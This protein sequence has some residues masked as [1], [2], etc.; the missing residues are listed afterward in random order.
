MRRSARIHKGSHSE[1]DHKT[2]EDRELTMLLEENGIAYVPNLVRIRDL[3]NNYY[4]YYHKLNN[5]HF[6][7]GFIL[8]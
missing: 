8:Q 3:N 2:P 7:L 1:D 4:H 5:I 6:F